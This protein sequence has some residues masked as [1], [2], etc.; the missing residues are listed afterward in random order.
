[1]FYRLLLAR[2]LKFHAFRHAD[3]EIK[4]LI[5]NVIYELFHGEIAMLMTPFLPEI[6]AD[7]EGRKAQMTGKEDGF[8]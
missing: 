8:R 6:S 4:R 2:V 7:G 3:Y 5:L 1:M